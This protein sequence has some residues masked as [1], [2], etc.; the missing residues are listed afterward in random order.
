[1]KICF[2]EYSFKLH[3]KSFYVVFYCNDLKYI[4]LEWFKLVL[5]YL[6]LFFSLCTEP[7]VDFY[8]DLTLSY[9]YNMGL[10]SFIHRKV[11]NST[12]NITSVNRVSFIPSFIFSWFLKTSNGYKHVKVW[13]LIRLIGRKVKNEMKESYYW[14]NHSLNRGSAS[15]GSGA[16]CVSVGPSQ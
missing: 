12:E 2:I 11:P 6:N 3:Q 1:M 14:L 10:S 7:S 4:W 13:E 8:F 9:K 16:A 5:S 15:C